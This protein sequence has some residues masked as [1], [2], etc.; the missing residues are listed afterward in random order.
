MRLMLIAGLIVAAV[1]AGCGSDGGNE[2]ASDAGEAPVEI[3]FD[4]SEWDTDFSNHS[5]PLEEFVGG[6]P[7]KDGIASIDDPRFVS[8][9]EADEFL[10]AREP[11][12][13][14]ELAREVRA[15]P[16]QILTWHE[17]VNDEIAGEP[18]AVTYCPL[19]NSTVAFRREVEGEPVEFG[20][21]GMLRN[22]DLVMYDRK[23]ESWWQQITAEAVVGELTGERLDVLP[24]QI[25]SWEELQ[26]LHPEAAVLSTDTGFE[27]DYG[28]NPYA[29]YDRNP[30][31]QPFLFEG[32]P[33]RSL[34]PKERVA[35]IE[36][37]DDSAVVYPFSRLADEA[38]INDE[39]DGEPVVVFFDPEVASALDT[40]VI[41]EGRDVGAAAVF[42]RR[43]AG[44]MLDFQSGPEGGAFRDSQTGS[45]WDMSGEATAGPLAG[46]QLEQV[47]HDDQFWFAL[48]AFF[49]QAEIRR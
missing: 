17:I 27:R 36:T 42:E 32:E 13:V 16:L 38:P 1:L 7:P 41:S 10:D 39:I 20:T 34:S 21:T 6:G 46:T 47:P 2:E 15:Y 18:V 3:P 25:L 31:S 40:A 37:G 12:A 44:R 30:N 14:V 26:R 11:V 5:A 48:A 35:A 45:T 4:T 8:V 33:D 28:T 9:E 24:S 22:S 29:A 23:T 43:V 49:P 19:C